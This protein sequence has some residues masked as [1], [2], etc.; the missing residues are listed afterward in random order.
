MSEDSAL[1]DEAGYE[2]GRFCGTWDGDCAGE[3]SRILE[4][5]LRIV[6]GGKVSGYD[7]SSRENNIITMKS[8]YENAPLP[9]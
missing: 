1:T 5:P 3:L 7:C 6:V 2:D 9:N 8:N 4:L